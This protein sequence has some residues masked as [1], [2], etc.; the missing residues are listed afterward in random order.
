MAGMPVRRAEDFYLPPPDQPATAWD[1]VPPAERVLRWYE[2]RQQRRVR[3][4]T[5]T[6]LGHRL[7]ARINH[8]R[9]VADCPCA[10][11]QVVTPTDP[12]LAC[13]ECGAGW[14]TVTFPPD[15]AA[16]EAAVADEYPAEQNWWN[17][18][19][20]TA[21]DRPPAD[22]DVGEGEAATAAYSD[23]WEDS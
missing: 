11:A 21:W 6:I 23:G 5:A 2:H 16:A 1:L 18:D 8:G 19:D 20:T 17:P 22:E 4:P 10:S 13:P 15:V 3:V 12:R 9:W 14:F 7:F